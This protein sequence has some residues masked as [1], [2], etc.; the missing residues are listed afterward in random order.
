M[1]GEYKDENCIVCGEDTD[2]EFGCTIMFGND[3]LDKQINIHFECIK[4][5]TQQKLKDIAED[6]NYYVANNFYTKFTKKRLLTIYKEMLKP[7][8]LTISGIHK[9]CKTEL[10][11]QLGYAVEL[12]IENLTKP[13]ADKIMSYIDLK[14]LKTYFDSIEL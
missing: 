14:N 2:C 12:A 11:S 7:I 6:I 10:E 1:I 9:M 5:I 3:S 4:S 8:G 13:D